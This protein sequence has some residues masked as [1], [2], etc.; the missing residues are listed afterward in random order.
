MKP[1]YFLLSKK[2]FAFLFFILF[3]TDIVHSTADDTTLTLLN[4]RL[5]CT[6][7]KGFKEFSNKNLPA[8]VSSK[9][10]EQYMKITDGDAEITMYAIELFVRT[11]KNTEYEIKEHIKTWKNKD[12]T[13]SITEKIKS[14]DNPF[15]KFIISPNK[16]SEADHVLFCSVFIENFD[17]TLISIG[18]YLNKIA[19]RD[20]EKYKEQINKI[21][22]SISPGTRSLSSNRDVILQTISNKV[23]KIKLT[24]DYGLLVEKTKD[25]IVTTIMRITSLSDMPSKLSIYSGKHLTDYM[26]GQGIEKS[27]TTIKPISIGTE[28]L[29][30]DTFTNDNVWL[31]ECVYESGNSSY[32]H[33]ILVCYSQ[34][35]FNELFEILEKG[36]LK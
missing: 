16:I 2:T 24:P 26:K 17:N 34:N 1:S 3:Y 33:F 5:I 21:I 11:S 27:E 8:V 6:L 29:I 32:L 10:K 14:A 12:L 18:F 20:Q 30:F 31:A 13:Y 25:S 35:V 7:P 19:L 9:E 36:E 4:S 15:T 28:E 22:K 23:L